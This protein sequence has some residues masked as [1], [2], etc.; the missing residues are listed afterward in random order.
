[1][2]INYFQFIKNI[3]KGLLNLRGNDIPF[4]PLFFSYLLFEFQENYEQYN[5]V[6]Y[7]NEKKINETV[8]NYLKT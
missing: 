5:G 6:L 4:T 7:I 3:I 2:L 8:R 1:M